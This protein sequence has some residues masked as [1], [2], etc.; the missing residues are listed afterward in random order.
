M[1]VVRRLIKSSLDGQS[2]LKGQLSA[3]GKYSPYRPGWWILLGVMGAARSCVM[4]RI[5]RGMN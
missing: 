2:P 1:L 5:R 4:V 3:M